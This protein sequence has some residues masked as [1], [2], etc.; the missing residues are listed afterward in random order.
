MN[1]ERVNLF[2]QC[3]NSSSFLV[4]ISSS[5]HYFTIC[6]ASAFLMIYFS[7]VSC[8]KNLCNV[9]NLKRSLVGLDLGK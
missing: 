8:H 5:C 1:T 3:K 2:Y 6:D 7:V 4:L 9:N